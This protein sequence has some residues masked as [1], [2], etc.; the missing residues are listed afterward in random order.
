M[1]PVVLSKVTCSVLVQIEQK[2]TGDIESMSPAGLDM[3]HLGESLG[4]DMI[5][6]T[7][8]LQLPITL[9]MESG[10]TKR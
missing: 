8:I 2:Q 3:T 6:A 1:V 5:A 9:A 4:D 10:H 7:L